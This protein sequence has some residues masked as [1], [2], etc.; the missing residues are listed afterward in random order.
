M[1][2]RFF[3][4]DK[5]PKIYNIGILTLIL[6]AVILV[7]SL[8]DISHK[9]TTVCYIFLLYF[10]AVFILLLRAFIQQLQYNPYSY[11]SIYYISFALFVISLIIDDLMLIANLRSVPEADGIFQIIGTLNASATMYMIYTVPFIFPFAIALCVSNIVL[12]RKEGF[13]LTNVLGIILS[14]LLISG[15][16]VVFLLNYY[17]SGSMLEVMI[18]NIIINIMAA[19]YLYFE[20]MMIGTMITDAIVARY[21]PEP[22]IDYLIVLGCAI[23]KD[24][25]PSPI[26]QGR[27]DRALAF[28]EKQKK[29]TGKQLCF[30]TSGGQGQDEIISES[31]AMKN[32]L[33][34]NGVASEQII[35]EDKSTDTAENMRFSRELI[36]KQKENARIAFSTTN[37]HV[38]R[39]GIHARRSG[40]KAEGMGARTKWYFWPNAAVREFVGILTGHRLKQFT[41]ISCLIIFY[42]LMAVLNYL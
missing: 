23:R 12:I 40:M 42:V 9:G 24:G 3:S 34:A 11:N 4:R 25:T 37:F 2:L 6:L 17:A 29:L 19:I 32:Y 31:E 1:K 13:S 18:H 26:L 21:E 5:K 8:L 10:I 41:V 33:V 15:E 16:I 39:S 28:Y 38:F 14:I 7:I 30:V 36:M 27:I 22:K 20:C 35:M